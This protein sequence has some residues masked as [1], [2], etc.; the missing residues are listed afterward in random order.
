MGKIGDLLTKIGLGKKEAPK[1]EEAVRPPLTSTPETVTPSPT[2]VPK[3]GTPPP[4]PEQAD[5]PKVKESVVQIPVKKKVQET[6]T[7]PVV[8][9][10]ETDIPQ[11]PVEAAEQPTP[12]SAETRT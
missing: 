9:K 1:T 8:S 11:A 10:E 3:E 6:T 5:A 4:P 7:V 12:G 2:D